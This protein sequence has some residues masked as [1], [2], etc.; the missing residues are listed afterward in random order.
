MLENEPAERID[1]RALK[2]WFLSG[3]LEG[4]ILLL[5]PLLYMVLGEFLWDWPARWGWYGVA[6][7]VIYTLWSSIVA[8][9][10]RIRFWRYEI[11]EDEIDI[12]HGIFIIRRTLIPMIRVQHV[13]TEYG[14][15]MKYFGLATL[16][17]STAA[18]DHRI[19]ALSKEKASKLLGE[20]SALAK[21][22]DE[23]V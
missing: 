4:L 6:V 12:Q 20:I 15:I 7:V 2:V 22:S 10:L 18:T 3:I 23:D 13:D 16:R 19:P 9:R 17:I 8:P 5:I 11:R 21:V 1:S 14:P